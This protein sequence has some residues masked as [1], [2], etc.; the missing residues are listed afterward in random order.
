MAMR[1]FLSLFTPRLPSQFPRQKRL[2]KKGILH[3]LH[4][5]NTKILM[6]KSSDLSKCPNMNLETETEGFLIRLFGF[7]KSTF[8]H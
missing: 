4:L 3:P 1:Q 5:Q 8:A 6:K 2:S 7:V